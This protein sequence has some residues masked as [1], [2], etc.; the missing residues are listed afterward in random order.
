MLKIISLSR[1][2]I[3][4]VLLHLLLAAQVTYSWEK[5]FGYRKVLIEKYDLI[6]TPNC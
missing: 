5:Y 2:K 3:V 4:E 6:H 1:S